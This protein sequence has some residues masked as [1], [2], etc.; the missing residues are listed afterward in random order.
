M[1]EHFLTDYSLN[2]NLIINITSHQWERPFYDAYCS[3]DG[4]LIDKFDVICKKCDAVLATNGEKSDVG[5]S[6]DWYG[7]RIDRDTVCP[8]CGAP[9]FDEKAVV[10]DVKI[11]N[12]QDKYPEELMGE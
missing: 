1:S 10:V 3:F 6:I 9:L 7:P 11:V 5:P 8:K 4:Y 2:E 12:H